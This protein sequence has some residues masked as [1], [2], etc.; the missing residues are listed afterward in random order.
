MQESKG[1]VRKRGVGGEERKQK[2]TWAEKTAGEVAS[3][4]KNGII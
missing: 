3:G 1:V 4:S 2:N